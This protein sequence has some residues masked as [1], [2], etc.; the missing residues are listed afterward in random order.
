[1]KKIYPLLLSILLLNNYI[2][3]AQKSYIDKTGMDNSVN[4]GDNFFMYVNGSWIKNAKIPDDQSTWGSFTQLYEENQKKLKAILEEASTKNNPKG[5]AEQKVGDF[6]ASGMDTITIE[7][8]GYEPLKPILQKIDA[9]KN[10]KELLTFLA[11]NN[12]KNGIG[13][14][15]FYISGDSKNSTKNIAIL[16][17][18]GLTLPE[19]GYYSRTDDKTIEQRKKL[20]EYA[21]K[22]F[23]LTGIDLSTAQQNAN[24]V[25]NLETKIAK[26][27]LTQVELRDPIRN[28]NK[29]S[30]ANFQKTCPNINW[31]SLFSIIGIKVDSLDV[32]QPNYYTALDTLLTT[33]PINVWKNKLKFDYIAGN[34]SALSKSFRDA[35]F[36]FSRI[37]SGQKV[38]SE[39]WK[40][41]VS[42]TDGE[43][44]DLLGQLYVQKY[45][46]PTAKKRMDELVNNLQKAFSLR[47][48]NLDWMSSE[49]KHCAQEKLKAFT[50]KIGYPDKWK[51][52][53]D[54]IITRNNYFAN[55]ESAAKHDYKEMIEKL[56]KPVDKT[57]WGMTPPTVNA[58]YNPEY[59]EIVF[60]AGILQFPFF[61]LNA[62]DAIN[63]GAIGMVIGHEM[64]HGFDDQGRQYDKDGNLKDWWAPQ[65]ADK[66]NAK[67]KMVVN[68]YSQYKVLDSLKLNGELTLGE[69]LADI[70]G[71]AI[72]YDAF[73]MTKQ[74]QSQKKIDGFTPD[75][76]FFLGFAQV[77]QEV[78]RPEYIRMLI[79]VDP[80][81]P[82][83]NRVNGPL[84]NF[85]PFYKTFNIAEKNKMY[86]QANDRAKI[87]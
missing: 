12:E 30:L 13:I 61:Q 31:N 7:K 35:Q 41:M 72:A 8:V 71:I 55:R 3:K 68:Q 40:K 65:D 9:L 11:E 79:N 51:N 36:D 76:R 57:E 33:E 80:H 23:N 52:F 22:L 46:P 54:V 21:T 74:G 84:S 62:D 29:M 66:F 69:N 73:K 17:Q 43:L 50:K 10:Y 6:Y 1:M 24:D 56:N 63:Y 64:T 25:L 59:N 60:P 27:H 45:F 83:E 19:K 28:Y 38:Q 49:T 86:R 44:R 81:S 53:D 77:W 32:A 5:S 18:T 42:A 82:S 39:R 85:E 75:Q 34:A 78:V 70:G 37:F 2:T 67:A 4:P 14:L 87:W 15:G 58:Y 48:A 16:S 47:I 20:V 26:S